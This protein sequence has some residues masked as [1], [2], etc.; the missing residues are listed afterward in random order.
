MCDIYHLL[1]TSIDKIYILFLFKNLFFMPTNQSY[2]T[3]LG[4]YYE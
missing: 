1:I 2:P 4:G 3:L